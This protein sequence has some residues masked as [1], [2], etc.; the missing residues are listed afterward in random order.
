MN[1]TNSIVSKQA[2][3]MLSD[4]GAFNSAGTNLQPFHREG[5]A[6]GHQHNLSQS[7]S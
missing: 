2:R 4:F 1:N 6:L 5:S 3:V 7:G